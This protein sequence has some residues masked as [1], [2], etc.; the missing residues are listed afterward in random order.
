MG[1]GARK[2]YDMRIMEALD[3]QSP[4]RPASPLLAAVALLLAVPAAAGSVADPPA[5]QDVS[6]WE[7]AAPEV[8]LPGREPAGGSRG[9]DVVHYDLDHNVYATC[10]VRDWSLHMPFDESRMQM[11]PTAVVDQSQ[12]R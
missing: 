2:C 7:K 4:F 5:R 3:R 12:P 1:F 9:Y 6:A 8:P 10:E 11:S